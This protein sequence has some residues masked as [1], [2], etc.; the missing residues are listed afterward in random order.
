MSDVRDLSTRRLKRAYF[1]A[2]RKVWRIENS[3]FHKSLYGTRFL[4]EQK[5][6]AEQCRSEILR[7]GWFI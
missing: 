2:L 4:Q 6:H 3:D 5:S 1:R 7:R